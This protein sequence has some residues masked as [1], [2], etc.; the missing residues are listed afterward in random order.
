MGN[1]NFDYE[2]ELNSCKSL[3]DVTGKDGLIQKMIKDVVQ[4]MLEKEMYEHLGSEKYERIDDANRNYRNGS[5]PKTLKTSY[6]EV[7]V[8]VPR[9]R[10]GEF[11]P[12]AIRKYETMADGLESQIIG[13]YAKGMSTRDIKDQV[14]DIYGTEISPTTISNITDKVMGGA[15]E[16]LS[17]PLDKVYPVMYL[18][19]IHF[20]VKEGA[21]IVNKAAYIGLGI[22]QDGYKEIVG[23][24]IGENEGSKFWLGVCNELKNRGIEDILI[25]CID[26]LKGFPDAIKTVFPK[27]TIQSCIIHQIRNSIKYIASKE[28]K[29]FMKD[30]KRVYQAASEEIALGELDNLSNKWGKKYSVIIDSWMN[31]WTNLSS[32]FQYPAA[33]RKIIYTTNALEGFNRQLRKAT[34]TKTIFPTDDSLKK[35]LYLA[36]MDIL[37]K[38]VSPHP[39][40]GQAITQFSILFEGRLDLG[41]N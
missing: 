13:M 41:L 40:W 34:K 27:T 30:L 35:S 9:D 15:L 5:S 6:G 3:E 7:I 39:N 8:D 11:N 28:Q 36:T 24:W 4:K 10:K 16:W 19:A 22:N 38:W 26:G 18:D 21:H 17:R 2:Q 1:T 33:V 31:N 29:E 20:K 14:Q 32:Y 37:K 25:A 23:I 12:N